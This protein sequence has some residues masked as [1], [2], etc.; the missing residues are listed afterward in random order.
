MEM[1]VGEEKE[2]LKHTRAHEVEAAA[3]VVKVGMGVWQEE[4]EEKESLW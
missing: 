2:V 1:E 4:E 3:A